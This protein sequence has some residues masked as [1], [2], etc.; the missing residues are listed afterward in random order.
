MHRTAS[1]TRL[2]VMQIIDFLNHHVSDDD[3]VVA[4]PWLEQPAVSFSTIPDI[5]A[6]QLAKHVPNARDDDV[7]LFSMQTAPLCPSWETIQQRRRDGSAPISV[8]QRARLTD[9]VPHLM[10]ITHRV[11]VNITFSPHVDATVKA[12]DNGNGEFNY[13]NE[14][15]AKSRGIGWETQDVPNVFVHA[16]SATETPCSIVGCVTLSVR[17]D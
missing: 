3:E 6:A 13:I 12:A 14:K 5:N 16:T 9:V 4:A 17:R 1:S 8:L 10:E 2:H 7:R 11:H 15:W